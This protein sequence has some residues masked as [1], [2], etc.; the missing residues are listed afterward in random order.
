MA[1]IQGKTMSGLN[2]VYKTKIG[3]QIPEITIQN[4]Y[5]QQSAARA[6]ANRQYNQQLYKLRTSYE[7]Q[8]DQLNLRI[9]STEELLNNLDNQLE[10]RREIRRR[11]DIK[12]RGDL[13]VSFASAGVT[14]GSSIAARRDL[15]KSLEL[16]AELEEAIQKDRQLQLEQQEAS[17]RQQLQS[18]EKR[19]KNVGKEVSRR[20]VPFTQ[21]DREVTSEFVGFGRV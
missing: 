9:S 6:N 3:A 13:T 7:E 2:A 8:K 11:E 5:A 20:I 16:R 17:S 4:F 21:F 12:E 14:G 15:D 18:V 19:L 10:I 1:L